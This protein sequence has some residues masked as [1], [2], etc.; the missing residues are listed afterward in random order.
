[1]RRQQDALVVVVEGFRQLI[2]LVHLERVR[3]TLESQKAIEIFM[4]VSLASLVTSSQRYR[5]FKG[6]YLQVCKNRAVFKIISG[7]RCCL[8]QNNHPFLLKN[9]VFVKT[10][11]RKLNLTT[12]GAIIDF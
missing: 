7:H 4:R 2:F 8:I 11:I 1:M 12:A 6:L 5:C 10:S 3:Q 9:L